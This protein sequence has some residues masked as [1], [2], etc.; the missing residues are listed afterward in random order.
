MKKNF[1]YS[2]KILIPQ[3]MLLMFV[4][5]ELKI[6]PLPKKHL[7]QKNVKEAMLNVETKI[8]Q[9]IYFIVHDL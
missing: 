7:D 6:T 3:A 2:A 4:L 5:K 9:K 1:I 8:C